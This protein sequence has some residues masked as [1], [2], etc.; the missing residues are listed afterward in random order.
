[1]RRFRTSLLALVLL[2]AACGGG[3]GGRAEAPAVPTTNGGAS[4]ATPTTGASTT[5]TTTEPPTTTTTTT[6]VVPSPSP[7]A[8]VLE[9]GMA[10]PRTEALQQRLI[11]LGFDPGPVDGVFGTSTTQAVWAFQHSYGYE[12]DGMVGPELY[13]VIMHAGPLE[14]LFPDSGP[15]R[16]V[17]SIERQVMYVYRDGAL[18]LATHISTGN[19]AHYCEQGVCG[20]AV[21]PTGEFTF[22][23]RM[24][25]WQ[26][27][28]LGRLYNPVFFYAGFAV[29]GSTSVPNRPASHGCVRIPMHIAEYFPDLVSNGDPVLVM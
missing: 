14:P 16:T 9:S 7:E 15:N 5:V 17:I 12:A 21:T 19:G 25:G 20:T 27:S 28:F 29:H 24:S 4:T 10:G 11:D 13:D 23:R 2:G 8:D 6:T 3:G 26:V 1:M 22:E 18:V